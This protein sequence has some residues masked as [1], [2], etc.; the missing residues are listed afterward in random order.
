MALFHGTGTILIREKIGCLLEAKPVQSTG[1][2]W[3]FYLRTIGL[4]VIFLGNPPPSEGS[5]C[6]CALPAVICQ[7]MNQKSRK[8]GLYS[9]AGRT[10]ERKTRM[11]KA[12]K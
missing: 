10:C 4:V 11:L 12:S 6:Y 8:K 3:H 7:G 9:Q 2:D 5:H 1:L